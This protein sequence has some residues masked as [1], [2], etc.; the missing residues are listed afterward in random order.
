[1]CI[2]FADK[3]IV[4]TNH[5]YVLETSISR[6][7]NID[8]LV[9]VQIILMFTTAHKPTLCNITLHDS[10]ESKFHAHIYIYYILR[11]SYFADEFIGESMSYLDWSMCYCIQFTDK[12]SVHP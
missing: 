12:F 9:H 4:F 3:F 10:N 5:Y 7:I 6:I 8:V 11:K 2:S 1:M